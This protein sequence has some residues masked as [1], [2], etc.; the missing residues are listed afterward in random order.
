MALCTLR[1]GVLPYKDRSLNAVLTPGP[2]VTTDRIRVF[3][4]Q[5]F[6]AD[7]HSDALL[8]GRDLD[9]RYA[10]GHVD[11]PRLHDG[12]VDFQVFSVVTKVPN[13][14]NHA[15]YGDD[16][17]QLPL[18]F[19][20][21]W[22]SPATWFGLKARALSQARELTRVAENSKLSLVL[23][24]S[25]LSSTGIKG[26]LA[27]EGMHALEGDANSLD[28][29]YAAG[30]RM[31]G[32]VHLFDN[33]IAGS[34][35]GV[36]KHGLTDF[37]RALV[38]R[39]EA[40]GITIDLAHASAAAFDDTL[41][42]ATRPLVVSHGG[43]SGTC[44]GL[45]NLTDDQIRSIAENGGVIGIGYWEV[46]I[47][48]PSLKGIVDATRYAVK[49]AGID[50]VGLGSDFDGAVSTPFDATGLPALTEALL[51]AGFSAEDVKK[52]LGENVRRVLNLNL[53]E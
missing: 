6:V 34:S 47:C 24:R 42:L 30:F 8:W 36:T 12:S 35:F 45:R 49:I 43:V 15:T 13:R 33:E 28:E 7:L 46:A 16:T 50:H 22:R 39:M 48:D 27:L 17:D 32:L 37:G 40:L 41:K 51:E 10:R 9:K 23:R 53:P 38:P 29:L 18:L 5:A 44:P 2:Y 1:F 31:M 26:L 11:L 52:V 4:E 3:H 25:D 14:I 20:A 21:A 19:F